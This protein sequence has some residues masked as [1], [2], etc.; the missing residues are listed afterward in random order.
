[1]DIQHLQKFVTLGQ[2]VKHK[3]KAK[4][5]SVPDRL[6]SLL[7]MKK[8]R[9]LYGGRFDGVV[10]MWKRKADISQDERPS[11]RFSGH[12][13]EVTRLCC[14]WEENLLFS[15]SADRT[16]KVWDPWV[17]ND[18]RACVQTLAG[19]G[20]TVTGIEYAD[21]FL[22]SS[23]TDCSVIIWSKETGRDFLLYPWYVKAQKFDNAGCWV[24]TIAF[25]PNTMNGLGTLY[26]GDAKGRIFA[27]KPHAIG[28]GKVEWIQGEHPA[29]VMEHGVSRLLAVSQEN[30]LILLGYDYTMRTFDSQTMDQVLCLENPNRCRYLHVGWNG[31]KQEVVLLDD[32]GELSVVNLVLEHT[33]KTMDLLSNIVVSSDLSFVEGNDEI[34]VAKEDS[35]DVREVCTLCCVLTLVAYA[36][37]Y[38]SITGLATSF[39]RL[40][41]HVHNARS[42]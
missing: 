23:S 34:L 36:L 30:L 8:K 18:R 35:I 28:G 13:G 4:R 7:Y 6:S 40:L 42:L 9:C 22:F 41:L 26:A 12:K 21:N 19:H 31:E 5:R 39:N 37:T 29:R 32:K 25:S 10:L 17:G 15:A 11:S 1:M 20:G 16:I 33:V 3:T 24:N 14:D 2:V 27:Y 38:L